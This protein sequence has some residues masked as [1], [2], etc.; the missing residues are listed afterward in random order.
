MNNQEIENAL[1]QVYLPV[2]Q[3][4]AYRF[5]H[6]GLN[7]VEESSKDVY[8][9]E[10]IYLESISYNPETD[11]NEYIKHTKEIATLKVKMQFTKKALNCCQSYSALVNLINSEVES[12]ILEMAKAQTDLFKKKLNQEFGFKVN[13]R[14]IR[15]SLTDDMTKHIK[16]HRLIDWEFLE[17]ETRTIMREERENYNVYLVKYCNYTFDKVYL[18]KVRELKEKEN[19]RV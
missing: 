10:I 17:D 9:K 1:K 19:E 8:G 6:Y 15:E 16:L 3:D 5:L 7:K 2:M 4:N 14:I 18:D 11:S 12:C 13:N